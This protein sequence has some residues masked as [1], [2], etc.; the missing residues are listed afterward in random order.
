MQKMTM[1]A[2]DPFSGE[3]QYS[4][5]HAAEDDNAAAADHTAKTSRFKETTTQAGCL[6]FPTVD[7]IGLTFGI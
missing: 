1:H 3:K 6:P 5:E 7:K 4:R 2:A